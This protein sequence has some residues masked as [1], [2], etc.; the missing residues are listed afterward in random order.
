MDSWLKYVP[1]FVRE[2]TVVIADLPGAGT[3]DPIPEGQFD[4]WK[5][6]RCVAAI[7]DREEIDQI[8]IIAASYGAAIGYAFAQQ[9]PAR[10]K[11]LMLAGVMQQLDDGVRGQIEEGIAFLQRKEMKRFSETV[12]SML[13]N[14][15]KQNSIP[16]S[17][18]VRKLLFNQLVR[19]PESFHQQY[20]INARHLLHH[21]PLTIT[22]DPRIQ[23]LIVTGEYDLFTHPAYGRAI[24]SRLDHA[25]FT[26]IRNA[27]HLFH[28]EQTQTTVRLIDAFFRDRPIET[29]TGLNSVEHYACA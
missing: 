24:A 5:L 22:L 21:P 19:L 7:L 13:L 14:S 18:I 29:V 17:S 23:S 4:L 20:I 15:S 2:S 25:L 11:H 16:R 1:F 6:G 12:I 28:L 3:A 10:V 8:D 27:D 9:C 26:T